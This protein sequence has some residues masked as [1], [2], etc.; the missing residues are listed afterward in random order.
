MK[1]VVVLIALIILIAPLAYFGY[2]SL[3]VS[4]DSTPR[5][6]V[7]Y[8]G[9]GLSAIGQRLEQ[10]HLAR[11][12]YV[13]YVTAYFLGLHR[14][15][16]AGTFDLSTSMTPAQITT[17][18]TIGG[19]TDYWLRLPEG[20]RN[21][22]YLPLISP[23]FNSVLFLSQAKEGYLFPD[24]YL[25]PAQ[26]TLDQFLELVTSNFNAKL[27][28]A[29]VNPTTTLDDSQSLILASILEREA[30]TIETKKMI[31]GIIQNRLRINMA[32][33]VDATVQYALGNKLP[34]PTDYWHVVDRA[35]LKFKSPYNTYLAPG[36]PPAPI[37]N[38]GLDS[39][40]AAYHPTSTDNL[41][42]ITGSDNQMHYAKTLDDH[43]RNIAKY[44]R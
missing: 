17:K 23:H 6:F 22:E 10:N 38:P 11:S 30:R 26:F 5:P 19:S 7:V 28:Q 34:H 25:I 18:L 36:L 35:D 9:D 12:R 8:K 14:Q 13:F 31:A 4:S 32:L 15:L 27:A 16:K 44:L 41:Y 42:Y 33:Q 21:L 1:Q 20:Q 40:V 29:K 39:L 3:P 2:G 24:S 37:C 43:N